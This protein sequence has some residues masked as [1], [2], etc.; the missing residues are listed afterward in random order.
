VVE[1]QAS[2]IESLKKDSSG[3]E[4]SMCSLKSDHERLVKDNQIL[5]RAVN[6]QQERQNQAENELKAAHQYRENAENQMKKLEQ[7]IVSL[8][9]HLS[10]Q[11]PSYGN[12]FLHNRSPDVF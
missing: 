4:S 6:I 5:A 8:R 1:E 11:Q 3:L 2:L 10:H 7:I 9:Y 12:E